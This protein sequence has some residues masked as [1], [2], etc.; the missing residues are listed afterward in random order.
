MFAIAIELLA[1]RY[2]ATQFND[3]AEA[4]WPP[5]PARL[6][7][8]M[9]A[10][11][12]D[13]DDPDPDP[14]ERAALRWLEDQ[15]AP[16]IHCGD[17]GQRTVVT[18][19]VPVNDPTALSRDL[20][21]TFNS[22]EQAR[23]SLTGAQLAGDAKTVQRAETALAKAQ[24]KASADAAKASAATGKE[25]ASIASGVLA[26]L[27]ENRGKQGRTYPTVIPSDQS[28][29]FVWESAVASPE[30]TRALDAVLSR[31]ARI[32]H[33]STLVACR[34]TD[35]GPG[36]NASWVPGGTKEATR[37]R[38][39]RTGLI[40]RL[41]RAYETHHGEEPRTL[42][43]GMMTYGRA[44]ASQ[45]DPRLPHLGGDWYVLGITR[46]N[47]QPLP[48]A[49]QALTVTR[50]VRGAV[51]KHGEQPPA[52]I[53]SGHKHVAG[54]SGPTPPLDRTHM[55][56]IPLLNAGNRHS[57]GTIFGVGLVLPRDCGDDD[58]N[59]VE[60]ALLAWDNAGFRLQLP[61]TGGSHHC[62]FRL[63]DLGVDRS[64]GEH[65]PEWLVGTLARR[66]RT[67]RREYWCRPSRR[68]LTVTPVALD[69]FPGNL[70]SRQP[71]TR[72]R[73][74]AEA[75]AAIA[76]ACVLAGL[77]DDPGEVAVTVRLET[78]LVGL[79]DSPTRHRSPGRRVYPIY[80]TG[81][82]GGVPRTCVHAEI[83]FPAPVRGPVLIGAGR[84]LG[85]GLC[86]PWDRQEEKR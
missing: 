20:S 64:G 72:D 37:L 16:A 44:E 82:G 58:R 80:R 1:G 62:P 65:E 61:G 85:Y 43:A 21:R 51:L 15:G 63:E 18:H 47:N 76:R 14:V 84:Y 34:C 41:E 10:A 29:W 59:S 81:G 83:E 40:D 3:R 7:S 31:V 4:E 26:V 75:E 52:E 8:A 53:I 48:S 38:V 9:V 79:P 22:L 27:P 55:A 66:R 12:A 77:A 69:R 57:D 19:F 28:V 60:K 24:A 30:D 74:Q 67:T 86:L 13:S 25:T 54:V 56:V 23:Q 6:Y 68:W 70:R 73:A 45:P 78:P 11:W 36:T 49:I 17:A 46:E 71:E 42:P 39:P 50:A 35:T 5:H 2:T 32:G 33:S